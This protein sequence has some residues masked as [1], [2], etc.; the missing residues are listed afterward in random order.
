MSRAIANTL[1]GVCMIC[2]PLVVQSQFVFDAAEEYPALDEAGGTSKL[3]T[4]QL[5]DFD[6][7]G[8]GLDQF[9]IF[10]LDEYGDPVPSGWVSS[11]DPT[12]NPN[13]PG[14][15]TGG[16]GV[17]ACSS[18]EMH[19]SERTVYACTPALDFT[20][21]SGPRI[22]ALVSQ[23]GGE[24][25]DYFQILIG[26]ES[27]GP[28][29]IDSYLT[30]ARSIHD[31]GMP[32][33]DGVKISATVAPQAGYVCIA[34]RIRHVNTDIYAQVDDLAIRACDCANPLGNP[35]CA[36][37]TQW[38][39]IGAI[40]S[41][42]PTATD[43]SLD[44]SLGLSDDWKGEPLFDTKVIDSPVTRKYCR[45]Q[46]QALD[47]NDDGV[48][49]SPAIGNCDALR[50]TLAGEGITVEP[51]LYVVSPQ[52]TELGDLVHTAAQEHFLSQVGRPGVS[53]PGNNVKLALVDTGYGDPF[54]HGDTL[55]SI[56]EAL[57][58]PGIAGICAYHIVPSLGLPFT[59]T[60]P[61]Q[62]IVNVD[63]CVDG[64]E[65]GC[66]KVFNG[67]TFI[68]VH[69]KKGT[70]SSVAIGIRDSL[71][72]WIRS[73]N[74]PTDRLV[75]NLSLGWSGI[76]NGNDEESRLGFEAF[77]TQAKE[78]TCLGAILVAASG[79]STGAIPNDTGPLYPAALNDYPAPTYKECLA[80]LDPN[81]PPN[82]DNFPPI[83][84]EQPLVYAVGAIDS[85][86]AWMLTRPNA[87]AIFAAYGDHAAAGVQ[88]AV[89]SGSSV[90]SVV[91]AAS[92]ASAWEYA[93]NL[94]PYEIAELV[95]DSGRS[96]QS[97][98]DFCLES[99][100]TDGLCPVSR[101]ISVC[102]AITAACTYAGNCP[103]AEELDCK[104]LLQTQMAL[105]PIVL[106]PTHK[107]EID[108]DTLD[109]TVLDTEAL[110]G[111]QGYML[112][113]ELGADVSELCP[114]VTLPSIQR[115]PW[116]DPQPEGQNCEA[117]VMEFNSPGTLHV[118][119]DVASWVWS[120]DRD[121]M[122]VQQLAGNLTE[123]TLV[124]RPNDGGAVTAFRLPIPPLPIASPMLETYQFNNVPES[125]CLGAN[126]DTFLAF[127]VDR[128]GDRR[129]VEQLLLRVG[130][131]GDGDGVPDYRDRCTLAANS[132]QIDSDND[133]YGNQC[134]ADLN[135]D[136]I[137]NFLDLA[138]LKQRFFSNDPDADFD[139]N[140]TVDDRDYE[141]MKAAFFAPPGPS[142][143]AGE[144]AIGY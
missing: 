14:N 72:N 22:E 32:F 23:R 86:E 90:A 49:E 128:P 79:N 132:D 6:S 136:C 93:P 100:K 58:C 96:L 85:G 48:V 18:G 126:I 44:P 38:R 89:L 116:T 60:F 95:Y 59:C 88:S 69:G 120:E 119:V 50:T 36:A 52:S 102:D 82:P 134:D 127:T 78:A 56:A 113:H 112:Y 144:C 129:S 35:M 74:A 83:G 42:T 19:P 143:F 80:L 63:Q 30:A 40:D 54:E 45:Y 25:I 31:L 124:C 37:E 92:L 3:Q 87:R 11:D 99:E 123:A 75:I 15:V 26:T 7:P 103:P 70:P 41:D 27:P 67:I 130:A 8:E 140:G 39:C 53:N 43:C 76:Y 122:G 114:Q 108:I 105:P 64:Q 137:V 110:C 10:T 135:N 91:A 5:F 20:T 125:L 61:E 77:L 51:D 9:T 24:P 68:A 13:Q 62:C 131:D 117:C 46:L 106:D 2:T 28:E 107:V 55:L 109:Q 121:S 17:A 84:V 1:I 47:G 118:A 139:G 12:C 16:S 94:A 66:P 133:G 104:P 29:T 81:F 21:S 98:A 115:S 141:L 73:A 71:A 101:R 138:I 57:F 65:I 34:H 4:C 111:A 97:A 33:A 142:D